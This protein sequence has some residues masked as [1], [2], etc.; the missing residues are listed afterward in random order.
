MVS[1]SSP[2]R[3]LSHLR[4]VRHLPELFGVVFVPSEVA[5]ELDAWPDRP[6]FAQSDDWKLI[7][8]IRNV[9]ADTW[10]EGIPKSLGPGESAAIA[11]AREL[12]ALLL[13]VDD[14]SARRAA[15]TL[16]LQ[17]IGVIGVLAAM[18]NMRLIDSVAPLIRT[19]RDELQFAVADSIVERVLRELG[20]A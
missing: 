4:V 14:R 7:A 10:H 15:T 12:N 5:N 8:T 16:G 2:L 13:L 17:P 6:K 20:E 19:I 1:D 18:R 9:S 3:A 11:L